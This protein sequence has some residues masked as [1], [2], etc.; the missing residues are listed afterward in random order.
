MQP[1]LYTKAPPDLKVPSLTFDEFVVLESQF[2]FRRLPNLSS[3]SQPSSASEAARSMRV[4]PTERPEPCC[5]YTS[6]ASCDEF[7]SALKSPEKVS[8]LDIYSNFCPKNIPHYLKDRSKIFY[9]YHQNYR[10]AVGS[11]YAGMA[12]WIYVRFGELKIVILLPKNDEAVKLNFP[13]LEESEKIIA[14]ADGVYYQYNL[15]A[16]SLITIPPGAMS[17]KYA[18]KDSFCFAGEYLQF[19]T[20]K[21]HLVCFKRDECEAQLRIEVAKKTSYT[22]P[23]QMDND[24]AIAA[25]LNIA[26]ERDRDIRA[27]FMYLKDKLHGETAKLLRKTMGGMPVVTML[28][29]HLKDWRKNHLACP[30]PIYIPSSTRK[31]RSIS[32]ETKEPPT[33]KRKK[34]SPSVVT[35]IAI[36]SSA[37]TLAHISLNKVS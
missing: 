31:T 36:C 29:N 15:K 32:P 11:P 24:S 10:S 7:Y 6:L 5:Y 12:E 18:L 35:D 16:G 13:D 22:V 9:G 4:P 33:T 26:A 28:N 23:G 25:E 3:D 17:M 14:K 8:A 19:N 37:N 27:G 20:L 30:A 2:D 1:K 21:T 34:S